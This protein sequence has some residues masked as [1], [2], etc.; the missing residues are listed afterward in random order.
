M[1][2]RAY[3]AFCLY[4]G[5]LGVVRIFITSDSSLGGLIWNLILAV[6]P[7]FFALFAVEQKGWRYRVFAVLWLLFFPNALYIFTDFIHLGKDPAM[8]HY[9]I[10]YISVTAIAG[11][12]AGFASLELMQTYW[13]RHYHRVVGWIMTSTI[14]LISLFG[15]YIGRF[16]RFNSW[17][18]LYEPL[19][20]LKEI[21]SLLLSPNTLPILSDSD[22][23]TE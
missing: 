8:T 1:H 19:H 17:D 6:V 4:A 5:L 10:V 20:F 3:T 15:V 7:Y 16:L 13:N 23:A 9:D 21:A 22:R 14:M 18:I 12:I 2:L 11:L